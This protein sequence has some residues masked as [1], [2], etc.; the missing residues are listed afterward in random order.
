VPYLLIV[1]MQMSCL[2]MSCHVLASAP[3]ARAYCSENSMAPNVLI[4][5][6]VCCGETLASPIKT[7]VSDLYRVRSKS[8]AG[9][10]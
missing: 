2:V 4:R 3:R 9:D 10:R 5:T 8:L 1:V 6:Y 7:S